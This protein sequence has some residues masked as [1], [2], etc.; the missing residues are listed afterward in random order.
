MPTSLPHAVSMSRPRTT[1]G[2]DPG[3]CDL[4]IDS[5]KYAGTLSRVH[6]AI[7][8]KALPKEDLALKRRRDLKDTSRSGATVEWW[9]EDLNS[10]NGTFV[11]GI[12][13]RGTSVQL[14]TGDVVT[15][16]TNDRNAA[17]LKDGEW[18]EVERWSDTVF[19]F[20]CYDD[21]DHFQDSSLDSSGEDSSSPSPNNLNMESNKRRKLVP[22]PSRCS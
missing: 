2:R 19:R 21:S 11:N 9:I 7:Y 13:L 8:S 22:A 1:I 20:E 4:V 18:W 16:G 5:E 17:E 15:L 3:R 12:A 6:C 10:T 14:R